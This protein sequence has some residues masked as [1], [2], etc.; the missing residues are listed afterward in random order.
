MAVPAHQALEIRVPDS[1]PAPNGH[2]E[3]AP[4]HS[5]V[6]VAAAQLY[7]RGFSR[8]QVLEILLDHLA[9]DKEMVRRS[10]ERV[11]RSKLRKWEQRQAWRDLIWEQSVVA[12]DLD[13]PDILRGVANK[14]KRG[15]VDAAKLALEVTGRHSS[16]GEEK[17][18]EIHIQIANIPRPD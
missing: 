14:A 11:A 6:Q 3:D 16:R 9:P 8:R 18:T 12:L 15:R 2:Q 5:A 1:L 4:R 17:P 13:V 10:R 7:G